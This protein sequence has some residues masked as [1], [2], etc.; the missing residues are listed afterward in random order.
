MTKK[1]NGVPCY[2]LFCIRNSISLGMDLVVSVHPGC[3]E[4][5]I[6]SVPGLPWIVCLLASS[7]RT[8]F[9][10]SMIPVADSV[11]SSLAKNPEIG[12]EENDEESLKSLDAHK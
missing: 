7:G 6:P 3:M 12:S 1:N 4:S 8:F 11:H 2:I 10:L 9:T 5:S